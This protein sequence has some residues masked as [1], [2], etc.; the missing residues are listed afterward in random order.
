MDQG[1]LFKA[2]MCTYVWHVYICM[3]VCMYI[4]YVYIWYLVFFCMC[5]FLGFLGGNF[6]LNRKRCNST[7]DA[8][9]IRIFVKGLKIPIVWQHISMK[10]DLKHLLMPS[11]K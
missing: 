3:Y 8:A 9:T 10:K 4:L 1:I 5:L 2:F 6:L 11:C 7:N